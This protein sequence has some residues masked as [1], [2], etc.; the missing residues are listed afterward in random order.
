M[1]KL[2][3]L[4]VFPRFSRGHS[5]KN[6]FDGF[7]YHL[8]AG[9]IR[10]FLDMND[11]H[12]E[13][14]VHPGDLTLD[15]ITAEILAYNPVAI[16]FS[17]Y[18]SNYYTIKL[19]A[20]SIHRQSPETI[21]ICGGPTATFS[22]NV[23][24][25][26]C[27]VMDICVRSYGEVASLELADWMEGRC[28]IESIP[29]LTYRQ[30]G[31]IH[32]TSDR[33]VA[34]AFPED[35]EIPDKQNILDIFPD[36]YLNGF[37]PALRAIDIGVLTSRG[38]TFP[39]VYCNFAAMS[40]RRVFYHSLDRVLEVLRFLERELALEGR[41][42]T[43]IA[44]NDDNFSLHPQRFHQILHEMVNEKFKHIRF[45]ADMRTE[46]LESGTF[47][48]LREAGFTQ[49]HF[50]LE[51]GVPR[52]LANIKKVREG[53]GSMDGYAKERIF[54]ERIEWAV[55]SAQSAG[56]EVGIS[57]ILGCPGETEVEGRATVDFV[58][59]LKVDRYAHNFLGVLAGT[60]LAHTYEK[61]G[62]RS[63]AAPGKAL[64]ELTYLPYNVFQVPILENDKI[65]FANRGMELFY[66]LRL[67][68]GT[69]DEY[70]E[71]NELSITN[72]GPATDED[73]LVP[74]IGISCKARS[75]AVLDWISREIPLSASLW[76]LHDDRECRRQFEEEFF[77]H[78]VP[79]QEVN[80]LRGVTN[81][82]LRWHVNEFS[83]EA[84]PENT[85][86]M[87]SLPLSDLDRTDISQ[88]LR[89]PH[90][91]LILRVDK[92]D[93]I[94]T[95]VQLAAEGKTMASW[96]FVQ[97]M[98]NA[99]TSF[100]DSCRWSGALCPAGRGGRWYVN[101]DEKILP[102]LSGCPVGR[103]GEPLSRLKER[104][105][106]MWQEET[107]RRGCNEC[108][109]ANICSK[110]LFPNPVNVSSF[111]D[112]R[113]KY[114]EIS[115]IVDGIT[116]ARDLYFAEKIEK[117]TAGYTVHTMQSVAEGAFT[118][119]GERIPLSECLLISFKNSNTHYLYHRREDLVVPLSAKDWEMFTLL[120]RV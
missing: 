116:L 105:R 74:V 7:D 61:F 19:L 94:D 80:T 102:C 53:G 96:H 44:I 25:N 68:T 83:V 63:K 66:A 18:D 78:G 103:A 109:V 85:R 112:I 28:S 20:E 29:G 35:S 14:F 47:P 22:D 15:E 40:G 100:A 108:P 10:A 99:R 42:Q 52:I 65:W 111:C 49:I 62:I 101:E 95:L 24:M 38:C 32:R 92:D 77:S 93:D 107:D 57:I 13:Q 37:I 41:E 2:H 69:M 71:T 50:G 73:A 58:D 51:S 17:C 81:G 86:I 115:A 90:H 98:F 104:V 110:C 82:Q 43:T 117:D 55:R 79:I 113:R 39:C 21:L 56:L 88:L 31:R 23:I 89:V 6:C 9:Y 36:P 1:S 87:Y 11:I 26:D 75:N 120:A 76:I 45:W 84:S 34:Q 12:T 3:Y 64:P 91:N 67:L 70:V 8:G 16:G 118:Q 48:L 97:D 5:R 60:E 59:R 27:Q 119:N 33:T 4:F 46:S 30:N 72:A 106:R 114:P 54:L